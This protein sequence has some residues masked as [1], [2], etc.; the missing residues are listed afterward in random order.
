MELL[1]VSFKCNVFFELTWLVGMVVFLEGL[2]TL[3]NEEDKVF[4]VI[5]SRKPRETY[6]V[7]PLISAPDGY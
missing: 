4:E 1:V 3:S 6:I 2:L 7:F 5:E